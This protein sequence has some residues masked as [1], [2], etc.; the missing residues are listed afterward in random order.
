MDARLSL[1][2]RSFGGALCSLVG[3]TV[4]HCVMVEGGCVSAPSNKLCT[5]MLAHGTYPE[6]TVPSAGEAPA[7]LCSPP[8]RGAF[9]MGDWLGD[10]QRSVH[11]GEGEHSSMYVAETAHQAMHEACNMPVAHL[12]IPAGVV[13]GDC[14]ESVS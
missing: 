6:S 7:V 4:Q 3:A 1:L 11:N 8:L 5:D 13:V 14:G 10:L 12:D 2:Q 9:L